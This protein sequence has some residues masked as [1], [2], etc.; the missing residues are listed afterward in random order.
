MQHVCR[1]I[2]TLRAPLRSQRGTAL[3]EFG[4]A[5]PFLILLMVGL[6]DF[7][8]GFYQYL[9]VRGAAAAGAQYASQHGYDPAGTGI[10]SAVQHASPLGSYIKLSSGYPQEVCACPTTSP[11]LVVLG[12]TTTQ[13]CPVATYNCLAYESSCTSATNC[14]A[15]LY[16][17]VSAYVTYSPLLHYSGLASSLALT[18]L[19][20]RRVQ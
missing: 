4:L 15:G 12:Q 2:A 18:S 11:S 9:Q 7:G 5:A 14:P 8:L 16:V 20:Y 13:S 17:V 10:T 19:A 1:T 6:I 3:V